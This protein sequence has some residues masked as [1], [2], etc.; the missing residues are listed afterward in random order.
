M[1]VTNKGK[2]PSGTKPFF[3]RKVPVMAISPELGGLAPVRGRDGMSPFISGLFTCLSVG[4]R[5]IS[6]FS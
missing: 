3:D 1:S 5:S 6:H 2:D 4:A